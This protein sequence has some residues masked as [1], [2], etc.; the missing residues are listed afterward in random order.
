MRAE[1]FLQL[2]RLESAGIPCDRGLATIALPPPGARRLVVMREL[3][4]RG[5]DPAKA[6]EQSGLFTRLEARLVRAALNG[7]SPAATYA[8]LAERSTHHAMQWSAIKARMMLPAFVL[9]VACVVQP[10]PALISGA[11]GP[12][13]YAW[14]VA[15][16]LL[17]AAV[18]VV[19]LRWLAG[20]F[21]RHVPLYGRIVVRSNLRDFFESLA[22]MLEA[23]I[24]VLE[25]LPAALDT[26]ELGDL[27]RDLSRMRQRIEKG[28]PFAAALEA[29]PVLRGSPVLALAHTG[30]ASGTLPEMLMRH[31]A[32]E[33]DAIAEFYKQAATWLPRL[34]YALV[35]IKMTAGIAAL[36]GLAPRVPGD[37]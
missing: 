25:A 30:E 26:V 36:G 3:S 28:A 15:S 14:Q 12:G 19:V 34:V 35:A 1:L 33:S 9:V 21:A 4:S 20:A 5:A 17:M 10:L 31:V 37:L 23:G 13:R 32:I 18:A 8:R 29:V 24:P 6:G 7:G 16:P 2:S 27:R 11:I 22:L